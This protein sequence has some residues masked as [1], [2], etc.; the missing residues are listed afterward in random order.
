MPSKTMQS[1]S[2]STIVL[3]YYNVRRNRFLAYELSKYDVHI[4]YVS[5]R[6]FDIFYQYF[7]IL[8]Q[9]F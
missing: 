8:H 3:L 5:C 6:Y 7:D 9:L 1:L 2:L 4:K